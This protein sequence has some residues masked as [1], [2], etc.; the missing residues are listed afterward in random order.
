MC[1]LVRAWSVVPII[2]LSADA[3]DHRMVLALDE[4]ADDDVTKSFSMPELL[5]RIRVALGHRAQQGAEPEA[6]VLEVGDLRVDVAH[7]EVGAAVR[8]RAPLLAA[9]C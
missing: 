2:V 6:P 7:H 4:G 9:T 8:H 5:A 3:T 1:R